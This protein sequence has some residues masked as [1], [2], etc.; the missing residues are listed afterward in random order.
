MLTGWPTQ[1]C[2]FASCMMMLAAVL[3]RQAELARVM[4]VDIAAV[5]AG[6]RVGDVV[7]APCE[8]A[9]DTGCCMAPECQSSQAMQ[10]A[11]RRTQ[12]ACWPLP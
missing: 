1:I 8:P 6:Q 11:Q 10:L 3:R 2:L 12:L 9:T 5:P 4:D 7:D